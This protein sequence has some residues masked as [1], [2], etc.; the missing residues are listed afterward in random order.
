MQFI[1]FNKSK[2]RYISKGKKIYINKKKNYFLLFKTIYS[3]SD[4]LL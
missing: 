4:K 2:Y 3:F 1:I